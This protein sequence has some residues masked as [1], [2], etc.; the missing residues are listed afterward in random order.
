MSKSLKLRE[1]SLKVIPGGNSLLSKR[2]EM[3]SPSKWPGYF[4]CAKGIVVEDL[5]EIKY[6]DFSHFSVGTCTL[7]YSNELINKPVKD[8]IDKG[9]M[10]TLN[11]PEE[12]LLAEKLIS[13]HHW[14]GKV[15]FARTGGEANSVAIRVARAATGKDKILING[16]HGW[17]DWYL[18]VNLSKGNNLD[19]H[20]LP[21]LMPSGVPK[22]L[23][24]T[25]ETFEVGDLI[26]IKKELE[27]G[28]YAALKMEV[29]RSQ[30][31]TKEYLQ[32]IRKLC[33]DNNTLL[34]FDECT[35]GFREAFGGMHMNYEVFPDLCILGKTIANGF[36]LTCVLGTT[37]VMDKSLSSFISSTF[38][39]ERIG[40]VA[41]LSTLK[42]MEETE[43][44]KVISNLG[45]YYKEVLTELFKD[46]ELDFEWTGMP[47]LIGYSFSN[48][49]WSAIK[50]KI[51]EELLDH[52]YL[53]GCLFYP[54][55]AHS[56]NDINDFRD[57]LSL[58]LKKLKT[59]EFKNIEIE[60]VN[61]KAHNTFK[62]L[63]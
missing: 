20:L 17:H 38:W 61:K 54:S 7:G 60:M 19:G 22:G 53:H 49:D 26:K 30:R 11:C 27:T 52:G 62:R 9:T 45:N 51:T 40:F 12:V 10:S 24:G 44:W 5:D 50:T 23:K 57:V 36:P 3:F 56:K 59:L 37:R 34:I 21:G 33:N 1:K 31:P 32:N 63:N 28:E 8:I 46:L 2:S 6:K 41:A 16:Y 48:C 43:S 15:R 18:S 25:V 4:S 47:S 42:V 14:A 13:M 29:M 55:I 39:T 58:V 35:S